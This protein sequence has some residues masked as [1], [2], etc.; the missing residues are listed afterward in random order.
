MDRVTTTTT[1]AARRVPLTTVSALGLL[2]VTAVWGST[3]FLLKGVVERVPVTDFLA[4]RF[5]V[6]AVAVWLI[7]PRSV[8]RLTTVER[9]NGVLLGLLYGGAQVLQTVGLQTTSAS[10]SGFVTGMYVVFTPLLGAVLLQA[11][12]GRTVWTAV[13]LATAGLAVLSLQGLAV[14]TG[15]ALTL[16]SAVL[17]AAHIVGLGVWS[18]SRSAIGLT[19]VQL[20]TVTLVCGAGAAPG[21][22]ALPATAGD[23]VSLLYMAV[24]AGA[25]ALVVQTWAQAH[26]PATRAAIIMT[27][28]PVF[29]GLFAVLFGGERLGLRVVVGGAMV[30]TA[31]YLVELGPRRP[32]E[33]DVAEEIGGVT[34]V[35]PV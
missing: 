27:M 17:Y 8:S 24:V 26:L 32:D 4:V 14:G 9:R 28:E 11:R 12:I 23:W 31:M 7:A 21:G 10:V 18:T 25:M 1:P 16:A 19:V 34:H 3:F 22:I 20:V 5:A 29:A 6:A 35:G 30:L 33:P 13:V 15:E 2:A